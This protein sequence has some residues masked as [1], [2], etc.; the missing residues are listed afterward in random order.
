MRHYAFFVAVFASSTACTMSA[1][2]TIHPTAETVNKSKQ[3][4]TAGALEWMNGT[5]SAA[6]RNPSTGA[7]RTAGEAWSL[8]IAGTATMTNSALAVAKGDSDCVLTLTAIKA[9]AGLYTTTSSIA[10]D[11]TYKATASA[12]TNTGTLGFYA[13]AKLTVTGMSSDFAIR[14]VFSDDLSAASESSK[15]SAYSQFAGGSET[16]PVAAPAYTGTNT[17]VVMANDDATVSST[18]G[19][20]DLSLVTGA[21]AGDEYRVLGELASPT[22]A[23]IDAAWNGATGS[24]VAITGA[25]VTIA[26]SA[27][28]AN[29]TALPA[30]RTVVVRRSLN[31]VASYQIF[32][33][34][35]AAP[36][37][38]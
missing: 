5:Y 30:K 11:G 4:L 21:Q 24:A 14:L 18:T 22:F 28:L 31:G 25:P 26:S 34:A 10:L 9:T 29:S 17:I 15:S 33:L 16:E 8:R 7:A 37:T 27:I 12:F 23:S 1:D 32:P 19:S 3:A 36:P 13:N 20:F 35:F 38:G 2:E 6:C